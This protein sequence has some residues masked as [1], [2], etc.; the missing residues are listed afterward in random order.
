MLNRVMNM[1]IAKLRGT[2]ALAA[3]VSCVFGLAIVDCVFAQMRGGMC[4]MAGRMGGR[5]AST[6]PCR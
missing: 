3:A 4:G 2:T 1:S 6:N 5:L